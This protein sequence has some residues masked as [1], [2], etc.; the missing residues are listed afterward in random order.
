MVIPCQVEP[1]PALASKQNSPLRKG[2][3][4]V[5]DVGNGVITGVFSWDN[6][7]PLVPS[8]RNMPI[9]SLISGEQTPDEMSGVIVTRP[10]LKGCC[11]MDWIHRSGRVTSSS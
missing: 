1:N 4:S 10:T 9:I 11:F 2:K 8:N 5:I 7:I 3:G 6:A